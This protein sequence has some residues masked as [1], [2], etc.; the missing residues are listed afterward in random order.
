VESDDLDFEPDFE[1][2]GDYLRRLQ[3]R[4]ANRREL[5]FGV[6]TVEQRWEAE[7]RMVNFLAALTGCSKAF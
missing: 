2:A 1:P 4:D 7:C 3:L 5:V 6:A